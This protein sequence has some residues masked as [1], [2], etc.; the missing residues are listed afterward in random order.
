LERP[1]II[2]NAQPRLRGKVAV[3]TGAGSSGP[4]YGTGKAIAILFAREGARVLL[5]DSVAARA[6]ETQHVI[7]SAGGEASVIAADVTNSGDC[8]A[9]AEAAVGRYGALHILVNNVGVIATGTVVT[10]NEDDWDRTLAVNLKSMVLTSKHAIPQMEK[11]GGGSVINISSIEAF[12]F[13]TFTPAIP[14][15]VSKGGVVTLTTQMAVQHG[16]Q[17]IRVN[18]IAPGFLYTPMVAPHLSPRMRELRRL[19]APL[20]TEGTAWDV[21]YAALYLVSDEARWVTGAV[22]PVDGG[23]LC[24]TPLSN[25]EGLHAYA[26]GAGTAPVA[27]ETL[28][29]QSPLPGRAR[30]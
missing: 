3:V 16:R 10:V 11:S 27:E 29:H 19:A 9:I 13:G 12:R 20:G 15:S 30:V 1:T 5:V 26:S 7:Q 21:A 25:F 8:R 22:L 18:C 28:P 23:L 6:E 24:A 17:G 2:N 4:G 14:Y